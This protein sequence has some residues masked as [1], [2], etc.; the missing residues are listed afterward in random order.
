MGIKLGYNGLL[1]E[2]EDNTV[3]VFEGKLYSAPLDELVRYYLTGF[4]VL[5]KPLRKVSKDV[6]RVLLRT[7]DYKGFSVRIQGYGESLSG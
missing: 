4:G 3:Y 1:V 7:R 6:V 5:P 2:I